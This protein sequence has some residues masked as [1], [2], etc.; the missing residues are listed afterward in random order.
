EPSAGLHPEEVDL[1]I[2][3]LRNIKAQHNTVIVIEHD[4]SII[5]SADEIIEMGPG[6]GVNGG[7][8]V[9]QGELAGLQN[10]K[11][12]TTLKSKVEINKHQRE[13]KSYFTIKNA[14][15]NN[16]KNVSVTIPENVLVSV[17][18][19]SGS[20]KSSLMLEAFPEKYPETIMVG[21]AVSEFP[22]VRHSLPIWVLWM[23]FD[24]YYQKKQDNQQVCS[25][26]TR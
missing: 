12:A 4:L 3:M 23:I 21:K 24:L 20:G 10:S 2:Q 19:V 7:E 6:A 11:A 16:L 25:A 18:G 17:C 5:K 9:Y 1:L 14:N 13:I 15:H 22:A 8:V 26:L